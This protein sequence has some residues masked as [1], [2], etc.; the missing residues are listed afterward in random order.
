M[1]SYGLRPSK[2]MSEPQAE[3]GLVFNIS[4]QIILSF[5]L[6]SQLTIS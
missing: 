4:L 6:E 3:F 5:N 2:A 1:L